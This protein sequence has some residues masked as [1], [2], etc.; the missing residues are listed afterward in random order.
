MIPH[1]SFVSAN[2]TRRPK[3]D[4]EGRLYKVD[5]QSTLKI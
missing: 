4:F 1:L 3:V 5:L 2:R